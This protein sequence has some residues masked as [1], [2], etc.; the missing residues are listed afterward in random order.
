ML[1]HEQYEIMTLRDYLSDFLV[2]IIAIVSM[3]IKVPICII[4]VPVYANVPVYNLNSS[5]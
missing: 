3:A 5:S 2:I 1:A 4:K